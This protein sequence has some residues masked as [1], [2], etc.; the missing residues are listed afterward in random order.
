MANEYSLN[1]YYEFLD[2]GLDDED[3]IQFFLTQNIEWVGWF[4][5]IAEFA[6]ARIEDVLN[7]NYAPGS[8]N[9]PKQIVQ[10]M[11]FDGEIFQEGTPVNAENMGLMEWNDMI[12]AK[13]IQ[14]LMDE[15]RKA[16]VEIAT[17]K[18][19]NNNN[20]PYNSFVA[21]AKNVD[22]ELTIIEGYYD[23]VNGRGV[24]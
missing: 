2:N 14:W 17:L 22:S 11:R 5:H 21:S 3:T 20:M 8:G 10:H 6:D 19:Q 4:D 15:L 13:K 24:V 16:L 9:I 7:E 23:E 18:G 12:N 1:S